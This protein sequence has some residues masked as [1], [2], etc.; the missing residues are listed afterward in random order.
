MKAVV[1]AFNQEKALVGAFSVITNLQMEFFEAL[2][3]TLQPAPGPWP[4]ASLH[5]TELSPG[6]ISVGTIAP[7]HVSRVTCHCLVAWRHMFSTQ[8]LA[9]QRFYHLRAT[10]WC[11]YLGLCPKCPTT[12]TIHYWMLCID[13]KTVNFL[14]TL[15]FFNV[16]KPQEDKWEKIHNR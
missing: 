4:R 15:K 3:C 2:D 16:H 14:T 7:R 5:H 10:N 11:Q 13:T 12:Y 1:A 8:P 6:T 9:G